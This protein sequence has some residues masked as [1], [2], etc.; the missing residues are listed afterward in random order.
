[1]DIRCICRNLL[2][3][4]EEETFVDGSISIKCK[5]CKYVTVLQGKLKEKFGTTLDNI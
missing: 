5:K 1:M 2:C 3:V 4:V